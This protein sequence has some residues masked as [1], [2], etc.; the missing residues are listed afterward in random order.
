MFYTGFDPR[1]GKP[2]FV[3]RTPHEKAMQ[4][5][6]LQFKRPQ[7]FPIVREALR[8]ATAAAMRTDAHL[9]RLRSQRMRVRYRVAP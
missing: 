7:N 8:R 4:R 9:A 3:P 5:A 6:L 1:T 2:V